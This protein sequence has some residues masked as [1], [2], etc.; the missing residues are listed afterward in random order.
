[1]RHITPYKVKGSFQERDG[2][3]PEE[4]SEGGRE[5]ECEEGLEFNRHAFTRCKTAWK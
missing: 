2:E 1:M 3:E 4:E 5:E